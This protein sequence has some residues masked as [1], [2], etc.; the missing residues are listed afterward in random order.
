MAIR[1][2]IIDGPDGT[3][4]TTLGNILSKIYNIPLV[5]LTYYEDIEKH[6]EQFDQA[7]DLVK[8]PVILDRYI[9]SEIAYRNVYRPNEIGI[10]NIDKMQNFI[11]N[12]DNID[13][14]IALPENKEKW[15]ENFKILEQNRE[16]MYSSEKMG[17]IYDEYYKI[18]QNIRYNKN[19]FRYD[20]FENLL[21]K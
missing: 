21:T 19:V 3:G 4:K 18:W 5:H 13:I 16:E 6:Q 1:T 2:F 8:R 11:L 15:L 7:A 12:N 10:Q 17:Q 14:I 9:F 20:M